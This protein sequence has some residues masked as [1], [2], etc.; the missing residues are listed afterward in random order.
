MPSSGEVGARVCSA[1]VILFDLD[2][3][4]LSTSELHR[5]AWAELFSNWFAAAGITPPY[6]EADYFRYIDGRPRFDA[7]QALL[8]S[9]GVDLPWGTPTDGP[10]LETICGLG[11]R[12]NASFEAALAERAPAP[13]PEVVGVLLRLLRQGKQLAVVSSSR[14]A[15]PVL[16]A[17][18]ILDA[19]ELVMDGNLADEHDLPGKPAPDTFVHAAAALGVTPERAVVVEDA[20]FGVAAGRAGRFGLTVGIDRGAGADALRAAGADVVV[21]SLAELTTEPGE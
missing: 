3:V 17:A 9:R 6:R 2:G 8:T 14:N 16:R 12:K 20:T 21:A 19:F 15:L 5:Q 10:E 1:E 13:F 11:N 18:G 7:V 4:L